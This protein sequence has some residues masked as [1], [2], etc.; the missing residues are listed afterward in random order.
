M[1]SAVHKFNTKPAFV[2]N[3]IFWCMLL[4]H[5]IYQNDLQRLLINLI[6]TTWS[7]MTVTWDNMAVNEPDSSVNFSISIST[8][9]GKQ[10]PHSCRDISTWRSNFWPHHRRSV[11]S[12]FWNTQQNSCFG[13]ASALASAYGHERENSS[14]I[15]PYTPQHIIFLS[16]THSLLHS[17]SMAAN[18][19]RFWKSDSF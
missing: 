2:F 12:R 13:G 14:Q 8:N 19:I 18:A 10:L 3:V 11:G 4:V 5:I 17:Q 1:Y 16:Y 15:S 7:H 6:P 9:T